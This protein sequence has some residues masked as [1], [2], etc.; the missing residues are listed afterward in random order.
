GLR[1]RV[2]LRRDD[3]V[4]REH[5]AHALA[6]G[7]PDD[8]AGVLQLVGLDEAL[9]ETDALGGQ[10]RVRHPPAKEHG[11]AP[12]QERAEHLELPRHLRTADNRV[13]WA[14]RLAQESGEG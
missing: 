13:E 10:E 7:L 14:R 2:D 11:L 9:A 8:P 4:G 3:S 1:P 6:T 5:E 12:R